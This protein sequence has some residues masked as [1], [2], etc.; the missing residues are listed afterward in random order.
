MIPIALKCWMKTRDHQSNTMPEQN[1]PVIVVN[2]DEEHN[3]VDRRI[4]IL[5][6]LIELGDND[7]KEEAQS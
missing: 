4:K 1:V 2:K 6:Y 5:N 7:N 3:Y